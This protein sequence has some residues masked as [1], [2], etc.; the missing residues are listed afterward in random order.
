MSSV[1]TE[2]APISVQAVFTSPT[3]S[4]LTLCCGHDKYLLHQA[5]VCPR[6]K[7]FDAAGV[8]IFKVHDHIL[9]R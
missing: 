4:D 9:A 6:S 2:A 5:I 1:I 7:F 3:Y 8:G